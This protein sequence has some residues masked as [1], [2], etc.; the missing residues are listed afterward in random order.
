MPGLMISVVS[1]VFMDIC[2]W[3]INSNLN[4]YLVFAIIA[5]FLL[6]FYLG[7]LILLLII[8][9]CK[10]LIK[11]IQHSSICEII[12]DSYCIVCKRFILSLRKANAILSR[13]WIKG[14]LVLIILPTLVVIIGVN[15]QKIISDKDAES[16]CLTNIDIAEIYIHNGNYQDAIELL[17]KLDISKTRYPQTYARILTDKGLC[18]SERDTSE[19]DLWLSVKFFKEALEIYCEN[20]NF[21]KEYAHIQNKLGNTYIY[22]YNRNH[23]EEYIFNAIDAYKESEKA[24]PKN[25]DSFVFAYNQEAL[26]ETYYLLSTITYDEQYIDMAIYCYEDA[27]ELFEILLSEY[28]SQ[29]DSD[30]I[31]ELQYQLAYLQNNLG[32]SYLDK[33]LLEITYNDK[34]EDISGLQ[35]K[36][37]NAYTEA[38]KV[39]S[40][41]KYPS[42]Y[43]MLQNNIGTYYKS[44]YEIYSDEKSLEKSISYFKNALGVITLNKDPNNYAVYQQN[45]GNSYFDLYFTSNKEENL[46]DAI[47]AYNE[48]LNVI[49]PDNNPRNYIEIQSNLGLAYGILYEII[50]DINYKN[51]SEVAY[52]EVYRMRNLLQLPGYLEYQ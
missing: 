27:A 3:D 35:T 11:K 50:P 10:L 37:I 48:V 45:L 14:L 39:F 51:K 5:C 6:S 8:F 34:N 12:R 46:I 29:E 49:T 32:N 52:D 19:N 28:S 18:Y 23:N 20:G 7:V 13:K 42:L 25:E 40:F 2:I 38:G 36:A 16:I 31:A 15:Y 44:M 33:L 26:G 4:F 9:I 22:I 24:V 21:N 1:V 17:N 43:A 47:N 41:M 30:L